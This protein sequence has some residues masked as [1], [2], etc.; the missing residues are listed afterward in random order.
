MSGITLPVKKERISDGRSDE[1]EPRT[2]IQ[3]DKAFI[4]EH[5]GQSMNYASI[6]RNWIIGSRI[7]HLERLR[8]LPWSLTLIF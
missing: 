1:V 8:V 2:S 4:T 6:L 7:R 5:T 3:S